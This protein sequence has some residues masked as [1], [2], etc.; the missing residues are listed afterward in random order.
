[1]QWQAAAFAPSVEMTNFAVHASQFGPVYEL[2]VN[3]DEQD[4]AESTDGVS[5]SRTPNGWHSR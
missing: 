2:V 1:M 5:P 3:H 4:V